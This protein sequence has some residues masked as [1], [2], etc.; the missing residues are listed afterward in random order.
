MKTST[1]KW[2]LAG[3]GLLLT[4]GLACV[5]YVAGC[6][7]W[8]LKLVFQ[9]RFAPRTIVSGFARHPFL[10]SDQ[11]PGQ[12]IVEPGYGGDPKAIS[13]WKLNGVGCRDDAEYPV[14]KK[15]GVSRWICLGGSAI[16]SGSKN[17]TTIP[18]LLASRLNASGNTAEIFNFGRVGWDSTQELI[19]LATELRKYHPDYLLVYDGRNDAFQ[20]SLPDYR[21]FWNCWNQEVDRELNHRSYLRELFLPI[22]RIGGWLERIRNP[23][24]VARKNAHQL[25]QQVNSGVWNF[26]AVHPQISEVYEG[27]LSMLGAVAKEAGCKGILFVL[28][29][30]ILWNHKTLTSHESAYLLRL[31]PSWENAM[32]ELYPIMGKAHANIRGG[33]CLVKKMDLNPIVNGVT[34]GFFMDDCHLTDEGNSLV[35]GW[36][37]PKMIE[38]MKRPV[39]TTG[40][41]IEPATQR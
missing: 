20:A 6:G 4:G 5:L 26:Y 11:I 21:P 19:Y 2:K 36:I 29:P 27:N 8:Y 16:V 28:Q 23:E 18:S 13:D 37:A 15:A 17:S 33:G 39:V 12:H 24:K 30:Q 22:W 41:R 40:R 32:K 7:L 38:M 9:E 35:A 10:T 14:A 3:A 1:P 34:S 31:Q 25:F